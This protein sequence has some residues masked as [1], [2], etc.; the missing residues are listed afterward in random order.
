V[1]VAHPEVGVVV[2][3]LLEKPLQVARIMALA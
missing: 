1:A 2:Q 3:L